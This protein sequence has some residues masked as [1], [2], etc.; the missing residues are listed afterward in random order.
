MK[1]LFLILFFGPGA[2]AWA[3]NGLLKGRVLHHQA[4]VPY[5]VVQTSFGGYGAVADTGG[6]FIIE[7]LPYGTYTLKTSAT[8]FMTKSQPVNF[9]QEKADAL[10]IIRLERVEGSMDEVVVTGTMKEMSRSDSP[11]PVEVF[12]P[13]FFRKNPTPSLFEAIGMI[14]GIQPQMNCNVCNTGDIHINGMDGP[15][16]LILIDGMPIVSSLSTVYGLNGIPNSLVER[17]EVVKGPASSLYGSDAMGGIINVITK[18]PLKAPLLSIDVFGTS[19]QEYNVD[20]SVKFKVGKTQS[21]LGV[22]YFNY[23][24]PV[25]HNGD[26]FTDV[27]LQNRVSVFN[28]WSFNR[29][30][31]RMASLAARYVY[32]D[33][34]GGE[35]NWNRDWRGSD[36]VYGESIYTKRFELIAN[37]QLPVKEKIMVQLSY[38]W[39]D[40]NS[41]Y[42]ATPYMANQQVAFGQAYLDKTLG[43]RKDHNFLLGGTMRYTFYDDNT[44]GTAKADGANSPMKTPLP[45]I[46]IQDEWSIN[47]RHK[48]LGGYRYDYDQHHGGVHSPRL[49]Y[50]FSPNADNTIRASFGTGY[51]VVNLFTEDHAAL[52]GSREVMI[53]EALNPERSYNGNLNYVLKAPFSEGFVG[54]DITGFY[55]YFTNKIIADFITDPDKIIYQ[56]LRGHAIS[57]GVSVNAEVNFTFPLKVMLGAS[58]MDVYQMGENAAGSLERQQQMFAPR[59]SG[60]FLLSYTVL[61]NYTI[62]LTGKLYGPMRLPILPNDFRPEYSPWHCLANVQV[63][64]KFKN[65]ME[66]YGGVK[67][68]LNFVPRDPLMR[69]FD[70]FD[71]QVHINNPY[72]YSFETSYNYAP[73]QG[74]RYFLGFRYELSRS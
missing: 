55:S 12:T 21:L 47:R 32:E 27:T 49:A 50:K 15:Y 39:H 66:I 14:N 44:P 72:G 18:N 61:K 73:L 43:K 70:P 28:K 59:W 20:A 71:K 34:W 45:G 68:L 53:T 31:D 23:Q 2:T 4:P 69:P 58:Y 36:S 11:V 42:G 41:Y 19:W 13:K 67:N 35:M 56:N 8:G 40:Q 48:L 64:R 1:Y 51:R 65:R 9:Q 29:K 33:R 57:Q 63:T 3:Q 10:T 6:N 60:N 30:H 17:I 52:T 38:N 37:Y 25:D 5:A 26:H 16:T 46:F 74:I 7:D 62:D 54:L 24:Q 22:N